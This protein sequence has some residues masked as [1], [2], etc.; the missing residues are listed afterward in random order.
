MTKA[1]ITSSQVMLVNVLSRGIVKF[2]HV[3]LCLVPQKQIN[4][5]LTQF[6]GQHDTWFCFPQ[7][8]SWLTVVNR[9]NDQSMLGILLWFE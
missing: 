3:H 4:L 8:N 9:F 1:I 2:V 5:K 6:K 7:T